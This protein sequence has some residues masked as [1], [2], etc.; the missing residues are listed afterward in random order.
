MAAIARTPRVPV[1]ARADRLER[2]RPG[3]A[4]TEKGRPMS[5]YE[6]KVWFERLC[7]LR[8][9]YRTTDH[10]PIMSVEEAIAWAA[11][12]LVEGGDEDAATPSGAERPTSSD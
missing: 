6:R 9:D 8:D 12:L 4:T 7:Q 1:L 3:P 2:R 5:R 10:A 11:R